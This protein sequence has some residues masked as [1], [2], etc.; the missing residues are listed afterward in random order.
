MSLPKVFV[1]PIIVLSCALLTACGGGGGDPPASS[2]ASSSSPTAS[3]AQCRTELNGS[4]ATTTCQPS[5]TPIPA[6]GTGS[7]PQS[8]TMPPAAG[9]GTG[10][11]TTPSSSTGSPPPATPAATGSTDPAPAGGT[12]VAG[13]PDASAPLPPLTATAEAPADGAYLVKTVTLRVTGT[14]LFN[15]ELLPAAG[16]APLYGRFTIAPDHTSATLQF[17]TS[18]L[19]DGDYQFR[20]AAFDGLAGDPT[21]HEV[22]AMSARTWT[23]L[24]YSKAC[25]VAS[26]PN[27]ALG[28]VA[29]C[30]WLKQQ[31]MTG[32]SSATS[33]GAASTSPAGNPVATVPP[34]FSGKTTGVVSLTKPGC[35]H[36][37]VS[38]PMGFLGFEA[39][40]SPVPNAGDI[41]AGDFIVPVGMQDYFDVTQGMVTHVW[42]DHDAFSQ[43]A[44]MDDLNMRC[45]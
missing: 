21:A 9:T 44:A 23:L 45:P 1:R 25:A 7:G 36:Y 34:E 4:Y 29:Q 12:A 35:L 41:L 32:I 27:P 30:N 26:G 33:S 19:P 18:A 39:F 6:A 42:V 3:S 40:G 2:V 13:T 8:S 20:I 15:V 28:A 43:Q 10:P 38:A 37:I 5:A 31:G 11:A 22:T 17:D 16:Y 24:N 14:S